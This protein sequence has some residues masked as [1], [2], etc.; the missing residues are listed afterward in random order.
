MNIPRSIQC[1]ALAAACSLPLFP[2]Q[3]PGG[4]HT[5][6]CIKVRPEKSAEFHKWTAEVITK[7]AQSR[8][9][10]GALSAWYLLRAVDPVGQSAECDYVTVLVYPGAPPEPLT[11]DRLSEVLKK[12]GLSITADEYM[13]RRDSVARLVS[14]SMYRNVM[15]VGKANKGGYLAVNY[16][17]TATID[18]WLKLEKEVWKPVAEQMIKEG[19]E[20]GWS[21]NLRARGLESDLPWQGVTVDVY[22]SWDAVFKDD[23]QFPDRFKKV[24][25]DKDMN[26]TFQQIGKARTMVRSELY[27]VDELLTSGK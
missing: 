26:A 2:Q 11:G 27:A 1:A 10:S 7:V 21:V 25:P 18:D 3:A 13:A 20:S 5:V 9:E 6:N 12:A 23:P 22:P 8:V 16:M 4:F 15:G 19:V 14:T 17:K 24:H